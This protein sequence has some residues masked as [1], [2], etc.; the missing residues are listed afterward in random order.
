M[1]YD[2]RLDGADSPIRGTRGDFAA[3]ALRH[4]ATY[5]VEGGDDRAVDVHARAVSAAINEWQLVGRF[6][7]VRHDD[8]ALRQFIAV[9][10]HAANG[11]SSKV[12][13]IFRDDLGIACEQGRFAG[14]VRQVR[15]VMS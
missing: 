14:L 12:L 15:G 2:D 4:F 13:R 10:W 1:P 9:H 5:I 8:D 3:R 11:S 7:R 6:D